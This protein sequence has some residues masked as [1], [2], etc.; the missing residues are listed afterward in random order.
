MFIHISKFSPP[1]EWKIIRKFKGEGRVLVWD[2]NNPLVPIISDEKGKEIE[3][4]GG[5]HPVAAVGEAFSLSY[6]LH[7]QEHAKNNPDSYYNLLRNEGVDLIVISKNWI[8]QEYVNAIVKNSWLVT[9]YED[10]RYLF[11]RLREPNHYAEFVEPY[12]VVSK[13]GGFRILRDSLFLSANTSNLHLVWA[14]TQKVRE[15]SSEMLEDYRLLVLYDFEIDGGEYFG[16]WAI[17]RQYVEK[18]GNVLIFTDPSNIKENSFLPEPFPAKRTF[19]GYLGDSFNGSTTIPEIDVNLFAGKGTLSYTLKEYLRPG[20]D[21]LFED[22]EKPIIVKRRYG[23]GLLIWCG[24]NFPY[25]TIVTGNREERKLLVALFKMIYSDE[26][27]EAQV[28]GEMEKEQSRKHR[29]N[30]RPAVQ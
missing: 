9:T 14:K 24:Y 10:E 19:F 20:S 16:G 1:E 11:L 7:N 28:T 2:Y 17:L 22:S 6:G 23:R 27:D 3:I 13:W 12:L 26:N 5:W 30:F 15:I 4:V 8:K 18:G 29:V 21:V 25:H